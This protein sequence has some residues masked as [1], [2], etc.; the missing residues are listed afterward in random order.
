[1]NINELDSFN[2]AD[3]VKFHD[4]LN[5]RLWDNSEHLHPQVQ[6]KL[7]EIARDFQEFLGVPDLDVKDV[8]ISG[9]NAAYNYTPNSDIDL[10][11]VVDLPEADSSEV[12]RELFDAKKFQYNNIHN[13]KIGGYDVELYVQNP[14]EE[15]HSQGIYS[16]LRNVWISVPRR[17]KAEIDDISTKSKYEDLAARIDDTVNS[18]NHESMVALSKKI[19]AM[20]QAGLEQHGEFS[21]DNLAFKL[22]RNNGYIKRLIDARN[23]ARDAELSL[24]ERAKPKQ[25]VTYGFV[26]ESPDGVNPTTKM[27]LEDEN[28]ESIV[29]N[30]IVD[31]A[32]RLGIKKLPKILIHH[33]ADWSEENHSFGMY[34]PERH[35]LHVS[36]SNRHLLDVLRTTAH[37]LCHCAQNQPH[38]LPPDA[39]E[40]GSR[41]ENEAHA[42][43]GVIMRD[44]AE[45]NPH[46]FQQ[47]AIA[48]SLELTEGKI[49]AA[50]AAAA[51]TAAMAMVP[52]G[53]HAQGNDVAFVL[54]KALQI[55]SLSQVT[56]AQV[57]GELKQELKNA[58]RAQRGDPN[59]QNQSVIYKYQ[60]RQQ[61]QQ[62]Q[63]PQVQAQPQQTQTTPQQTQQSGQYQQAP[64]KPYNQPSYNAPQQDVPQTAVYR[65]S[66]SG[67][68]PKNKKEA[69]DP[70]YS[71]AV[72][73]DVGPGQVGKEANKLALNTGRN[74][75]PGLLMKSANLRES[76]MPQ[77]SQGQ[78][79]YRDL[80]APLGPE[81]KPTMPK[82]TVRVDVSDTYDWYKLGK[83]FPNLD[84]AKASEFG[85]GPPST[86]VSFGD[87]D[88]EHKYIKNLEKLGL[89]TTDIDP[90]DP[91]QPRG[92]K[93]QKTDPTYNVA[94]NELAENLRQ[95]LA[96][97]EE[98][99]MEIKMTS[100]NL[101]QLA[102]AI[103]GVT[104]GLEF[105]MIV[106]NTES[107]SDDLEP[108]YDQDQRV[109]DIDDCVSFYDDG[110]YNS[111]SDLR[112][113]REAM[114][115]DFFDWQHEQI[116]EEW[117]NNGFEFFQE[118]LDREEPF[119]EEDYLEQ[120]IDMAMTEN[121][122]LVSGTDEY[123]DAV[124]EKLNEINA[125]YYVDQWEEQGRNYDYAYEEFTDEQRDNFTESDWLESQNI[126]YASD[127]EMNYNRITWPYYTSSSGGDTDVKSIALNFMNYMGYNTIAVGDY[128]GYGGGYQLWNGD[129]WV[130]IGSNKPMDAFT[131]EP[132]GSLNGNEHSD[133]G[134]EFVSPPIP[135]AQIGDTMKK[136]QQWAGENGVY[137]GKSNKTSM[138]TN[139]SIPGYDLDKLDYL[140]A[141]IL[142]GDEH[143][144]RQFDRIGNTYAKPAIEK[145]KELVRQKP[146]KAK[147]LLD[148]MKSHLNAEAS[149]LIHSGQTDKYTSIN[150]KDNR[151]EYR[152]PGGDYLSDIADNPQKMVDTINRM[153]VNIDAAMDPEKYKQE[154]QK[155]LYKI[156]TGQGGGRE[157]KTGAKQEMKASDKDLIN[158]F[159]RYAAGEL[160][161]QALK[162][163]VRQ[164]QLERNVA[165][166]KE[167]GKMW[168]NVFYN[169]QRMEVVADNENAA[170]ITAAK[171]WGIPTLVGT[172]NQ[173]TAEV[174]RPY[175]ED[176]TAQQ[177]EIPGSNIYRITTPGGTLIAGDEYE[178]DQAALRRAQYWAQHRNTDV[179]VRNARGEEVGRVSSI[180]DITPA[181]QSA[182]QFGAARGAPNYAVVRTSDGTV[183][184]RFHADDRSEALGLEYDFV[185][186]QGWNQSDYSLRDESESTPVPGST[187]DL[188]RQR[189]QAA[190]PTQPHPQGNWGIWLNSNERFARV[191]DTF[192]FRR[193]PSQEAAE[194]FLTQTRAENP[195]M[196]SDVEVRE[197]EP[198]EPLPD[199]FPELP[200][201]PAAQQGSVVNY[202]LYNRLTDEVIDTFPARNDNEA[203][204][205]LNDYRQ[206]GA[207]QSSPD[208]FGVRRGPGVTNTAPQPAGSTDAAQG[209][210]VD[211]ASDDWSA[212]FERR[213][214]QPA[215][216]GSFTGEWKVVDPNGNEIYRFGGVGNN[217]S[218]ANRVAMDW[219]RRNPRHMQGGVEV[220]PVM[221]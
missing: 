94:E 118:Y 123:D 195:R 48:E 103:P 40:T 45:A 113:L 181:Q 104:V 13:I 152:S 25:R 41:W 170:K 212:E 61:Q 190:Q 120:A 86:I 53:A 105:E 64:A 156:L 216:T 205:R 11:L 29:Q 133:A 31:T 198:R 35:E 91:R 172:L 58:I 15:H 121:P 189:A 115:S 148:K 128:H 34:V 32:E 8:T 176:E 6:A 92:M 110:D 54:G 159:T 145:V 21:S 162:S 196:R 87:E 90:V 144:L 85:K 27:F 106:P 71:M 52:G 202:E 193:F 109:R 158:I 4:R 174:L 50:A 36:L 30:F 192:E 68:I 99:L 83:H 140:K 59:A 185:R 129:D 2:L 89:T 17:R 37:E 60:V 184:H 175:K 14:H 204:T 112:G 127:V 43:A 65:E 143:V 7:M 51:L 70:R 163:F 171:E 44:F 97:F 79:K 131:V 166:G 108:D 218:D 46:Y 114:E 81:F 69:K 77:P 136:V 194:Q 207:G 177:P 111:R 142:L 208:H 168:W 124:R 33:D 38:M 76:R 151:I 130:K 132:D 182:T 12:Y 9:S 164:A 215:T 187:L 180:G 135:L 214:Q 217:Q 167:T 16:L 210:I 82:G 117:D 28:T 67:Y 39:G 26:S 66:A 62:Q 219:L 93:R 55:Y 102:K 10:H 178:N 199:L 149:K 221:G 80:N 20:R 72:T 24:A 134:L 73:V 63:E 153:V 173:M 101:A 100:K 213:V 141:A 88:T 137:T 211:V 23:A 57:Q 157:A 160:P 186:M 42:V 1:M 49:N 201:T 19:K 155:K 98:D 74:G 146:D 107:D 197:I 78:G 119:D 209:G 220:L 179:V 169:G 56:P 84:R 150:T 161:K 125:T 95:E 183:V 188:Q 126:R 138:H 147:E 200:G 5:H 191:P 122:N 96:L 18:G 154:Y 75:E 22:L 3:T 139:I 206:F 165:K 116:A 203:M 47:D